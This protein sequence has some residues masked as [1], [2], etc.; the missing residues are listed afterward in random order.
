MPCVALLFASQ[1]GNGL[2]ASS[3]IDGRHRRTGPATIL[4]PRAFAL[5]ERR[6]IR[7]LAQQME[8]RCGLRI[9]AAIRADDRPLETP[10]D[11]DCGTR[12]SGAGERLST[13]LE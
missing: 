11:L 7:F 6:A 2:G 1:K 9:N 10:L 8:D 3:A 13:A 4:K 5:D 12:M